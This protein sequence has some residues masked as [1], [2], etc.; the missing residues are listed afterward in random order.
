MLKL[1]LNRPIISRLKKITAYEYC[2]FPIDITPNPSSIIMYMIDSVIKKI[3]YLAR[4]YGDFRKTYFNILYIIEIM[5]NANNVIPNMRKL[6]WEYIVP[7]KKN[8]IPIIRPKMLNFTFPYDKP[9]TSDPQNIR[10][11][12]DIRADI[13]GTVFLNVGWSVAIPIALVVKIRL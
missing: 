9:I 3:L 2:W 8:R 6:N 5:V 13:A 4:R 7:K 1:I 10:K 12:A 11:N